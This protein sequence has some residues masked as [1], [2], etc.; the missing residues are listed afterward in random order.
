MSSPLISFCFASLNRCS[1]LFAALL[2]L[3]R[4]LFLI[5][6]Q[7]PDITFEIILNDSSSELEKFPILIFSTLFLDNSNVS[8]K[9]IHTIPSGI[10]AAYETCA[11]NA[12]GKYLWFLADDD[13]LIPGNLHHIFD[14]L[15]S[16]QPLMIVLNARIS[17]FNLRSD[18]T[19]LLFAEATNS[20]YYKPSY[21]HYSS[22]YISH[23]YRHIGH[24]PSFI[25]FAVF[26]RLHWEANQTHSSIGTEFSHV[27]RL[28][29]SFP[30][31]FSL[32]VCDQPCLRLRMNNNQWRSRAVHIWFINW[33]YV[34][35]KCY[36][37]P[38]HSR[39]LVTAYSSLFTCLSK[40]L[41]FRATGSL[42]P[43]LQQSNQ[44][45]NI[46]LPYY[47]L[48]KLVSIFVPRSLAYYIVSAYAYRS[49]NWM[50]ID[51]LMD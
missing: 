12:T 7:Y 34:L 45:G 10:D 51:A 26:D 17:T 27:T 33:P 24:S 20:H 25:S 47:I 31:S 23:F 29:S 22:S 39:I 8:T 41:F 16:K 43:S 4:E 19:P 48:L 14:C 5:R 11:D 15:L 32:Y 42:S 49:K 38:D 18:Y 37:L 35:S 21:S 13:V 1:E 46:P 6:D 28:F 9:Y 44:W 3:S 2:C 50:I 36:C 30:S 40:A